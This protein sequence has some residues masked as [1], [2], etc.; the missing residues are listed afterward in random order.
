MG[1]FRF[2]VVNPLGFWP[3]SVC[4][5]FGAFCGSGLFLSFAGEGVLHGFTVKRHWFLLQVQGRCDTVVLRDDIF[6][7][8]PWRFAQ[9]SNPS[10][11]LGGED[12]HPYNRPRFTPKG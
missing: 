6:H 4:L 10:C 8:N 9:E 3:F 1:C 11:Y 7:Q 5:R 12:S 2:G